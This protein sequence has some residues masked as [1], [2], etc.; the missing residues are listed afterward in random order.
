M[1]FR[2]I[3]LPRAR[4]AIQTRIFMAAEKGADF[5]ALESAMQALDAQ[6]GADPQTVGESR[7]GE[8]RV[9]IEGLLSAF[10]EV[11]DADRVVLVYDVVVR[12]PEGDD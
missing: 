10:F 12:W 5:A 9:A 3:W 8:E 4:V 1:N 7:S 6:L 2:V 11:F